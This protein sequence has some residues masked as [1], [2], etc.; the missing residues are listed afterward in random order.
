MDIHIEISILLNQII[1][2]WMTKSGSLINNEF[3][4]LPFLIERISV[5]LPDIFDIALKCRWKVISW[6]QNT[7]Y[8]CIIRESLIRIKYFNV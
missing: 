7:K 8:L 2:V 6:Q 4:H 5:K 1:V 3:S